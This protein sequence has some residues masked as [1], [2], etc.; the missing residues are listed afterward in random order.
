MK[1]PHYTYLNLNGGKLASN[2][3]YMGKARNGAFHQLQ[4]GKLGKHSIIQ[5]DIDDNCRLAANVW[6]V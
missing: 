4:K 6:W 5:K 3:L 1:F 2:D